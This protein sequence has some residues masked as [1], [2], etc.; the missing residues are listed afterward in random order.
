M[1]TH[2]DYPGR[3]VPSRGASGLPAQLCSTQ[4][5]VKIALVDVTLPRDDYDGPCD[6]RRLLS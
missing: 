4:A 2:E 1:F 6:P 5:G 3:L